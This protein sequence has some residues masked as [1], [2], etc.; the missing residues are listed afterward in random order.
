MLTNYFTRLEGKKEKVENFALKLDMSKS[1]DRVEWVF[2]MRMMR[3][4]GFNDRWLSLINRCIN[5]VD[6]AVVLNGKRGLWFQSSRGL[7]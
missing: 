6:Y 7:S 1:Y 4:L 5:S 2:V 3:Q